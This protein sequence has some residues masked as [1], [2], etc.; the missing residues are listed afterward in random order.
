MMCICIGSPDVVQGGLNSKRE[1]ACSDPRGLDEVVFRSATG[2][3]PY[4]SRYVGV[5]VCVFRGNSASGDH[6]SLCIP[7]RSWWPD[8]VRLRAASARDQL[9]LSIPNSGRGPDTVRL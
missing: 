1:K 5:C 3:I 8:P 9:S 6:Q 4:P 2:N 7:S